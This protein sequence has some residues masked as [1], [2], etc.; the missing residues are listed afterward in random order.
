LSHILETGHLPIVFHLL[1]Y[2]RTTNLSDPVDKFID[3]VRFQNL[4]FQLISP[5]IQIT[6]EEADKVVP[7]F[8]ASIVSA[9]GLSKKSTL[10]D[11]N[12][13]L[14]GMESLVKHKHMLRKLWQVTRVPARKTALNWVAKTI[15][16]MTRGKALERW[17][18]KVWNCEVTPQTL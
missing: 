8:T 17:E 7:Y 18:T 15:R 2:V 14:P 3:W 11:M 16:I 6:V 1:D 4:A 12:Y 9:Y 13:D 5:R 10:S